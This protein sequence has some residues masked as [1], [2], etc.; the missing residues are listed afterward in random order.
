MGRA[1]ETVTFNGVKYRRY[2]D[3]PYFTP[4][5]AD[6]VRG[7]RFLHQDIWA[8][9]HGPIPS[10]HDVH[11]QDGNPLN[12][13]VSNLVLMESSAHQA[14]H[15]AERQASGWYVTPEKLAHLASIRPLAAA[16]H[17]T[18]EGHALHSQNG[19]KVWEQVET[20]AAACGQCGKDF[21]YRSIQVPIYCSNSCKSAARRASGIDD[22]V[23]E[24]ARCGKKFSINRYATRRCC[25]R[26]CGQQLRRALER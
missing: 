8:A 25:S 1:I 13:D 24:C 4:G 18:E 17:S 6:K 7:A 3:R 22:E 5:Q 26:T 21:E 9:E 15:A 10:G 2:E 16:W 20:R 12:N 14:L 23:R 19:H 11:H